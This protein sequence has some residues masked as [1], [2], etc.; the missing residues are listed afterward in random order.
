M[1]LV[2]AVVFFLQEVLPSNVFAE[3]G[4]GDN[5]RQ[6]RL[7]PRVSL[8]CACEVALA[9]LLDVVKFPDARILLSPCP[10]SASAQ[11]CALFRALAPCV[12]M[13][14]GQHYLCRSHLTTE[15]ACDTRPQ[16][17]KMT[18]RIQTEGG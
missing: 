16:D 11:A 6:R 10:L 4:S 15:V 17:S 3:P 5:H 2:L 9:V 14:E 1:Q 7:V 12:T 18:C 13:V 8:T